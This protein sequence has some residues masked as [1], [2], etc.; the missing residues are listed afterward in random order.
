[1]PSLN[2]RQSQLQTERHWQRSSSSASPIQNNSSQTKVDKS[3]SNWGFMRVI[4][5]LICITLLIERYNRTLLDML[6]A[7]AIEYP[8]D[9]ESHLWHLSLAYNTSEHPIG[10]TPFNL[11]FSRQVTTTSTPS[12]YAADM[13]KRLKSAYHMVRDQMGHKLDHLQQEDSRKRIR[14][15]GSYGYFPQ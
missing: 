1:M 3:E 10:Y 14:G 11:T 12:E 5:H 15:G 4:R 2:R 9:W 13:K 8:F 6:V 7:T